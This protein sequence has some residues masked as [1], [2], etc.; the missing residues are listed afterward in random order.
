MEMAKD[1][2]R[3]V[4]DRPMVN[5]PGDWWTYN[6]GTTAIIGRLISKCA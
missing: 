4:L 1:R 6:G 2:Y 5:E 3:F